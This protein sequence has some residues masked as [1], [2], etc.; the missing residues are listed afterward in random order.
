M[1]KFLMTLAAVVALGG[2]AAAQADPNRL[3]ADSEMVIRDRFSAEVIGT[4]PDVVLIPGLASSRATWRATAERLRRS[5][6]LHLIQVAGFAGEP[7]RAN[8]EGEVLAPTADAIAAY[9]VEQRLAPATI[10][11]HSLGGTMIL[12]LAQR[13]PEVLKKALVVDAL[14]FL[15]GM[16]DPKATA[17]SVKP[18]AARMR[19]AMISAKSSA[20][21]ANLE[22]QMRGMSKDAATRTLVAEWGAASDRKVVAR[23]MYEDMVLDL[24][25]RLGEI[26]TPILLLYP[27]NTPLNV[28]SGMMEKLYPALYAAAP[29]VTP[30]PVADS[31]HFV[32]LDQPE[33]FA[34]ALEEFLSRP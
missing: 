21:A 22:P 16:Q 5:H 6:R 29:T 12:D 7:A 14:P 19:D 13:R 4:G 1:R 10:V 18:M 20:T 33:A 8:S 34:A 28:P 23:M 27:D 17:E 31:Q 32:M 26:R 24:R 2:P 25:P 11:G 9:L 30:K 3:F 15:G